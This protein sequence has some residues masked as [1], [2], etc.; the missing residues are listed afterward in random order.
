MRGRQPNT[1]QEQLLQ[2]LI[3]PSCMFVSESSPEIT[4]KE[5]IRA[6]HSM[7]SWFS[8]LNWSTP[9]PSLKSHGLS[10]SSTTTFIWEIIPKVMTYACEIPSM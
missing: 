1:F 6:L 3:I 9:P 2:S 4:R 10:S 5:D 7:I 8:I